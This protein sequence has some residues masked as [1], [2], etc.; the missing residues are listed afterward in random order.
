MAIKLENKPNVEAPSAAYPYGAIKDN[1]GSND[2]T[3]VNTAVYGDFHQFFA[4]M[5][6][7]SGV[8]PNGLPDNAVDGFQY[9]EAFLRLLG[10]VRRDASGQLQYPADLLQSE[11]GIEVVKNHVDGKIYHRLAGLK[12]NAGKYMKVNSTGTGVNYASTDFKDIRGSYNGDLQPHNN[13]MV[14]VERYATA[15]GGNRDYLIIVNCDIEVLT[16]NPYHDLSIRVN[17]IKVAT[18]LMY[19]KFAGRANYNLTHIASNISPGTLI[20]AYVEIIPEIP[21]IYN[22]YKYHDVSVSIMGFPR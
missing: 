12:D 21:G 18:K 8:T 4:R 9:F 6:G 1:T 2:G 19:I 22:Q 13:K 5:L 7:E 10:R 17:G 3:P 16:T 11:H 15:E 14:L 20:D